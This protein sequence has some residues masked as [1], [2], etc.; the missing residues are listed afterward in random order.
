M[1]NYSYIGS[2]LGLFREAR[3]WKAYCRKLIDKYLGAEVLEVGA[4]IGATTESLCRRNYKRW[5]CLEPDLELVNILKGSIDSGLLPKF[6]EVKLGTLLA[7]SDQERFE[8]IIYIDVLEH[9]EDD[10]YEL[11]IA[12][13]HLGDGGFLVVL[14]PA[15]Q[16]LFTPFDESIGHYRRYNR[17]MLSAIVP[18]NLECI[19][20]RYLDS[21]GLIAALGNRFLLKTKMPTKKQIL[22]WDRLIIPL[23]TISDPLLQSLVGKS[24]LGIWKKRS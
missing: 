1:T 11:D 12:S 5:V 19:G 9:I 8:T 17:S 13:T 3:N 4:G 15:H 7:I 21:I 20:L 10:R 22:F 14:A 2:E 23:S 18:R 6:C 24:I 16:W